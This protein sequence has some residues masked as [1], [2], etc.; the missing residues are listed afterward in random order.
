MGP[1]RL[2]GGGLLKIAL[3][4]GRMMPASGLPASIPARW[5]QPQRYSKLSQAAASLFAQQSGKRVSSQPA[6]VSRAL[7]RIL[8]VL[9]AAYPQVR[10]HANLLHR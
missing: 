3:G 7:G 8:H 5:H 1:T 9:S 2:R 10:S 4:K 6:R